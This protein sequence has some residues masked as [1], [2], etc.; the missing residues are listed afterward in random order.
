MSET[1]LVKMPG[2]ILD[3]FDF[4]FCAAGECKVKGRMTVDSSQICKN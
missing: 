4:V 2:H 1:I 3:P